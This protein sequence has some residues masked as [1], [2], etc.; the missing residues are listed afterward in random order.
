MKQTTTDILIIGSGPIGAAYARMIHDALPNVKIMMIDLGPKVSDTVGQ[1]VK[2][3]TDPKA[4][5]KAQVLSQGS[6]KE[7]YPMIS[8]AERA[9]VAQKGDIKPEYLA[10]AGTH[11]VTEDPDGLKKSDMPAASMSSNLGGMGI[12]PRLVELADRIR[13][14]GLARPG[15]IHEARPGIVGRRRIADSPVESVPRGI[16]KTVVT[17]ESFGETARARA[18]T[19]LEVICL[20]SPRALRLSQKW[21]SPW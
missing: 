3:I 5:E 19:L 12:G 14:S 9:I 10:R 13:A 15:H 8:V 2:N 16:G 4:Q 7:P 6:K 11:L 18:S 21:R 1:H 17:G 20:F